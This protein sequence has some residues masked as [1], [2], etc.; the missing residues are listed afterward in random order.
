MR[1]VFTENKILS[2]FHEL[3]LV[4]G[5]IPFSFTTNRSRL[6]RSWFMSMPVPTTLVSVAVSVYCHSQTSGAIE[7]LEWH[8]SV[9]RVIES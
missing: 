2:T 8:Y 9:A 6:G 4:E 7:S 5:R 1:C 3:F